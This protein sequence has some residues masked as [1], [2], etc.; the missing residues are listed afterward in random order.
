MS[1]FLT[2]DSDSAVKTKIVFFCLILSTIYSFVV[3]FSFG[4]IINLN[5]EFCTTRWWFANFSNK[6]IAVMGRAVD[7]N[8]FM[9]PNILI[10]VR[11]NFD[12][13]KS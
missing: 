2:L 8:T 4:F 10:M 13:T 5:F 6:A 3:V 1:S 7:S 9:G 12:N 11:N